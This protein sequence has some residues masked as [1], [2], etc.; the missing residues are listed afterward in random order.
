MKTSNEGFQ[1]CYNA[2]AAVD[3]E[4]QL[5]VATDVTANASDQGGLPALLD[6]VE[7][8]FD[9]QPDTVLADAGYCNERDLTELETRGVDGYVATG[10]EAGR[11][12]GRN[13]KK[14]PAMGRMVKKLSTPAGRAA[15]AERKWL[16]EAPYGWIHARP[17]LPV[18]QPAW[19]GEGAGRVGL[20]VPGGERQ[21]PAPSDGGVT[22]CD[23]GFSGPESGANRGVWSGVRPA[24]RFASPAGRKSPA[25]RP[26][27]YAMTPCATMP[28]PLAFRESP[29]AQTPGRQ[30]TRSAPRTASS[31]SCSD[32]HKRAAEP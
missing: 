21:A 1:Q 31:C 16:S 13:L 9:M 22:E 12:A 2:Q 19:T 15:Y 8:S 27:E 30:S 26:A 29:A 7:E 28:Q 18:L 25:R 10:R 5:V 3:A 20:G 14:H 4:H 32:R 6:E 17:G 11:V 24:L 23:S